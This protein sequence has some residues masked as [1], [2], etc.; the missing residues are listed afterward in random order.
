MQTGS[1]AL[2]RT[3]THHKSASADPWWVK[4]SLILLAYLILGV[5]V[6]IPVVNVFYNALSHG[7]LTYWNNVWND[8]DTRH[9]I[10]L[11]LIVAP[12]SVILNLVFGIMAAWVITKFKFPGRS[13]LTTAID[14]PFAVSPVVAGLMIMLLFGRQGFFGTW[15]QSHGWQ[16]VFAWPGL[17]IATTFVTLPFIARELIPVMEALGSDEETAAVSLGADGWQLFWR[18]TL[19]NIKWGVL[20]GVILCN[21]RAMGEFGAVYVVSGHIAGGTD[22]MPLRVEKLFQEYNNPGSFAVASLLT[23]LALLTLVLK[24]AL[25][26]FTRREIASVEEARKA[27]IG[28][29]A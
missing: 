27:T 19:P 14:L 25:E 23:G 9:S 4:W 26:H 5:L 16:I 24:L 8:P 7:M 29:E 13:L 28:E 22:T 3:S 12:V 11:T 17:V 20:Y 6:V 2:T 21:S 1:S 10:Y 18:V 15:L